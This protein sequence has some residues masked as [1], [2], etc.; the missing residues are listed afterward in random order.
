MMDLS[1]TDDKR[2]AM[3]AGFDQHLTKPINVSAMAS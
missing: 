1:Q 2:E 3:N